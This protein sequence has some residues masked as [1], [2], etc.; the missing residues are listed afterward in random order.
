M[1]E[2]H[3]AYCFSETEP[4]N[5]ILFKTGVEGVAPQADKPMCFRNQDV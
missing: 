1:H 2:S 3:D 4:P 5:E